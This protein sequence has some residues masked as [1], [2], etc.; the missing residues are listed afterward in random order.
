MRLMLLAIAFLLCACGAPRLEAPEDGPFAPYPSRA[1]RN[2]SEME[3]GHRLMGAGQHELAL[4]AFMR[5]AGKDGLTPEVLLALGSANLELGRLSQ[6]EAQLRKAKAADAT[7][8]DILNNLG[9]VL[10]EQGETVE[11][12]QLFRRAFALDNGNSE[13]IRDN[14]RK[15]LAKKEPGGYAEQSEE[16]LRMVRRGS[17]DFLIAATP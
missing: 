3:L 7:S 2:I 4:R 14:L 8:P 1:D 5:A 15:A 17:A 10:M 12:A 6:A 11:A 16:A 9:V 13:A